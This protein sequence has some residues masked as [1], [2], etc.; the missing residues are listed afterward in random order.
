MQKPKKL[1]PLEIKEK[2]GKKP[3]Y[4]FLSKAHGRRNEVRM[5]K[6][7]MNCILENGAW[8]ERNFDD[9]ME[10]HRSDSRSNLND[11]ELK[12][13]KLCFDKRNKIVNEMMTDLEEYFKMCS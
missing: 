5:L 7:V 1:K 11:R 12:L 8:H 3:K 4:G 9:F 6:E 2:R 13:V 10:K